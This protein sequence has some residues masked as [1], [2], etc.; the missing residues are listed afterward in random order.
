[1]TVPDLDGRPVP[2]AHGGDPIWDVIG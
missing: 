1:M 2:I